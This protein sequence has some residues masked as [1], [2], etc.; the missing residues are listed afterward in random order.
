M[1][2]LTPSQLPSLREDGGL[3]RELNVLE[4][5]RLGLPDGLEIFHEV[6]WHS[7]HKGVDRH[8]EVDIVVLSSNGN[9]L[10]M[11]VKAGQVLLR[12]GAPA[13]ILSEVDL[14]ELTDQERRKLFVGMTRAQL[15]LQIV[16][17]AQAEACFARALG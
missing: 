15:S 13:V 3:F 12:E 4:P 14:A 8:G 16:L 1:A 11:E 2:T 6:H 17:S 7:V 9:M 10:L 5:L